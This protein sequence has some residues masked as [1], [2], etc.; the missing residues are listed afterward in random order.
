MFNEQTS[1][2]T[3]NY[4]T[5][6]RRLR[7]IGILL[8]LFF[9]LPLVAYAQESRVP[10]LLQALKDKNQ[11]VRMDAIKALVTIGTPAFDSL[12]E[13]LKEENQNVKKGAII[14]LGEIND[15]RAIRPLVIV[16][17]KTKDSHIKTLVRE[18]LKKIEAPN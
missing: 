12:I 2:I 9:C 1:H 11:D 8:L 4:V 7:V 6:I 18:A 15:P 5:D 13:A 17:L 14:A 16:L 10:Q 3:S